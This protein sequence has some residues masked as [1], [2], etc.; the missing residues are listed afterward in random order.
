MSS[1]GQ[2]QVFLGGPIQYAFGPT[3]CDRRLRDVI[4]AVHGALVDAGF[5][6]ISAHVVEAF[7]IAP[8]D[9]FPPSVVARRDFDWMAAT[10]LYI[11][12]LP[13]EPSGVPI[14]TAGTCIELGWA[15][16]LGVP[17]MIGWDARHAASYSHLVQAL[18]QVSDVIY[19]DITAFHR[20]PTV[21][22]DCVRTK[23]LT[24]TV[25]RPCA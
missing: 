12:L 22:V 13:T 23:L 7:G 15:S 11:A 19:L 1:S 18:D 10:D 9:Q 4:V 20:D 16:A 25:D 17:I 21:L 3:A 14:P 24:S 6:V 8:S 5:E 2:R